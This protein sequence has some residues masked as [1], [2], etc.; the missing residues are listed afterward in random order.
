MTYNNI[1]TKIIIT[2]L[3]VIQLPSIYKNN[4]LLF[5]FIVLLMILSSFLFN[6]GL[7]FKLN[8]NT[9]LKILLLN[10]IIF[11][12]ILYFLFLLFNLLIRFY[13]MFYRTLI[14]FYIIKESFF[15]IFFY[16][17]YNILCLIISVYIMYKIINNIKIYNSNLT[18]YLYIFSFLI[19]VTLALMYIDYISHKNIVVNNRLITIKLWFFKILILLPI[20]IFLYELLNIILNYLIL[21]NYLSE[22][23]S[24][25]LYFFNNDL[26]E[27]ITPDESTN[28]LNQINA[29]IQ[30]NDKNTS[31]QINSNIKSGNVIKKH[32]FDFGQVNPEKI[33]N[34]VIP[35]IQPIVNI[36]SIHCNDLFN[37]IKKGYDEIYKSFEN[38]NLLEHYHYNSQSNKGYFF[39]TK[40]LY[41]TIY[42]S[43][44]R[45][46]SMN[47]DNDLNQEI[48]ESSVNNLTIK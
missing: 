38:S 40:E 19:S 32:I 25:K 46:E 36:Y 17:I 30:D 35:I 39:N 20:Y 48:E 7:I 8:I 5:I 11:I 2:Y 4:S 37:E 23:L 41:L 43:V 47:I 12:S 10:I 16:Y 31:E 24:M 1:K 42:N 28:N 26:N 15:L 22:F 29:N 18:G 44:L 34:N 6:S 45:E 3:K 27:T 14:H 9:E 13:N 33:N 21:N